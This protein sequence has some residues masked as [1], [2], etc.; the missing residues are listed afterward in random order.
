MNGYELYVL[1]GTD[2]GIWQSSLKFNLLDK[3]YQLGDQMPLNQ[4][5]KMSLKIFFRWNLSFAYVHEPTYTETNF[6][7]NQLVV[8]YG[9]AID[10]LLGKLEC[11]G[12]I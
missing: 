9:P 12:G 4:F 1:D 2:Y 8:G 11:Y 3:I 10:I 5:K 7:N 6:L